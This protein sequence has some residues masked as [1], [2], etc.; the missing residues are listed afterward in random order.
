MSSEQEDRSLTEYKKA[1]GCEY[2]DEW[3]WEW[4]LAPFSPAVRFLKELPEA[5][6]VAVLGAGVNGEVRV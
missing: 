4:E 2:P 5:S 6:K 3:M 1:L